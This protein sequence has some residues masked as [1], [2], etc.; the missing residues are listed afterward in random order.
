MDVDATPTLYDINNVAIDIGDS[1]CDEKCHFIIK[2][3]VRRD[4]QAIND[5]AKLESKSIT[6]L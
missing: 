3:F 5:T 2:I 1:C 4:Y 6:I